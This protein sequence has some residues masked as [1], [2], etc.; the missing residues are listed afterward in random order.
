VEGHDNKKN[1]GA[2]RQ[3]GTTTIRS[4]ATANGVYR[5]MVKQ[6]WAIIL[7]VVHT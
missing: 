2:S 3:T 1:S 6:R 7:S 4:G 5:S